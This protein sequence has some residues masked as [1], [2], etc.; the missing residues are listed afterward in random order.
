MLKKIVIHIDK[1]FTNDTWRLVFRLYDYCHKGGSTF[2]SLDFDNLEKTS[3]AIRYY[4]DDRQI[5][6]I[7]IYGD[8]LDYCILNDELCNCSEFLV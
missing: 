8:E 7:A 5:D 6:A 2:S 1:R 3:L 4:N